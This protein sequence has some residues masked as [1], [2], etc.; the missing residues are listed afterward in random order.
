M[1]ELGASE[2]QVPIYRTTLQVVTD[3]ATLMF[4]NSFTQLPASLFVQCDAHGSKS[5]QNDDSDKSLR[6]CFT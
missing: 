3:K 4:Y 5:S 1:E 6:L 2:A